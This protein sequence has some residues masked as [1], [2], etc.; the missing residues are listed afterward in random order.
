VRRGSFEEHQSW[1]ASQPPTASPEN[2]TMF[3]EHLDG[4]PSDSPYTEQLAALQANVP[5]QENDL[6][7]EFVAN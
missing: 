5:S 6:G 4:T 3:K 1:L 2:L 7:K